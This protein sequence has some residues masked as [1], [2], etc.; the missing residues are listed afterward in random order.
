MAKPGP[1]WGEET[2]DLRAQWECPFLPPLLITPMAAWLST[3][4]GVTV[5][6]Q[7]APEASGG[8]FVPAQ[9]AFFPLGTTAAPCMWSR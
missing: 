6:L 2:S 7:P 1:N 5:G 8:Q 3:R 4:G 9:T